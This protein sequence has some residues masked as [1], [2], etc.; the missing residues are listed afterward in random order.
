[1]IRPKPN[2]LNTFLIF[3]DV[4]IKELANL[5]G[6]ER[7]RLGKLAQANSEEEL[8]YLMRV[9]EQE[10]LLISIAGEERGWSTQTPTIP[11]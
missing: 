6:I 2:S 7:T 9:S 4:S 3:N 8:K 11:L 1:M 5:A 10:A